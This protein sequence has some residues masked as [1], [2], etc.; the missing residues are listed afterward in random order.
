[1]FTDLST[2]ILLLIFAVADSIVLVVSIKRA[3]LI[4]RDR[5]GPAGIGFQSVTLSVV[6]VGALCLQDMTN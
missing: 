3:G 2:P 4:R 6:Y 1:M 5:Q